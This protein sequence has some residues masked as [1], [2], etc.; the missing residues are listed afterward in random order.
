V[1]RVQ[2]NKGET[3]RFRLLNVRGQ[4]LNHN[5]LN[6]FLKLTGESSPQSV[7]KGLLGKSAIHAQKLLDWTRFSAKRF[8]VA[9]SFRSFSIHRIPVD[10]GFYWNFNTEV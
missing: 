8:F 9:F 7:P 5:I 10:C 1:I 2:K 6:F 4:K 3:L